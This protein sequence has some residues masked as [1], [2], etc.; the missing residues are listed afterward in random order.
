M[1]VSVFDY[2]A[3]PMQYDYPC[4]YYMSKTDER[5]HQLTTD[6]VP[7]PPPQKKNLSILYLF[8]NMHTMMEEYHYKYKMNPKWQFGRGAAWGSSMD[9]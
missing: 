2:I 6:C 9:S 8:W 4:L 1:Y 7:C 3:H 5:N